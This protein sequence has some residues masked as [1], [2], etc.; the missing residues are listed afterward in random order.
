MLTGYCARSDAGTVRPPHS[1]WS[2][3]SFAVQPDGWIALYATM[4][5]FSSA[6][7]NVHFPPPVCGYGTVLELAAYAGREAD[8]ELAALDPAAAA[9]RDEHGARD[10]EAEEQHG[11]GRA[12]EHLDVA[13]SLRVDRQRLCPLA[14]APSPWLT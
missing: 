13:R 11:D 3:F 9:C 7:Q 5:S 10:E 8:V 6:S 1:Q 2:S 4:L 14:G 12:D